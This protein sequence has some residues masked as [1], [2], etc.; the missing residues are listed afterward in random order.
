MT[1]PAV[2]AR[3]SVT[4]LIQNGVYDSLS[5]EPQKKA[6]NALGSLIGRN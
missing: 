3:I 4:L 6:P 1:L 2:R 5:P